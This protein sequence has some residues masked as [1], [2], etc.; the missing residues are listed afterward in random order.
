MKVLDLSCSV[1]H[2][3]EGWFASEED[4]Q[5]QLSRQL[6]EC[7]LCGSSQI[8]KLLSAPRLNLS[9]S[10]EVSA[11]PPASPS[12]PAAPAPDADKFLAQVLKM[13]RAVLK[14]SNDVGDNFAQEA[15]AIHAH[16]APERPIHG[17]ATPAEVRE[18]VADG[19]EVLSIPMPAALVDAAK[20][21]LH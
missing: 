1:S 7:P 11:T 16:E 4:F 12:H 9:H 13:A 18:L 8:Q 21:T 17:R 10:A 19:I 14:H 2:R 3:F 20:Q 15:R 5:S 6:V